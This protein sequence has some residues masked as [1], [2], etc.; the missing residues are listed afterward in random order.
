LLFSSLL[1]SFLVLLSSSFLLSFELIVLNFLAFLFEDSF[2]QNC[3]VLELVTLGGQVEFMVD[4]SVNLFGSSVFLE[5][6]SQNSLP[7]DP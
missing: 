6:S 1:S 5:K 2:N 7:P 4:C 3:S